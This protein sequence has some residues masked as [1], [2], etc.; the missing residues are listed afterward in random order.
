MKL[1]EVIEAL[2]IATRADGRS[3]R[4]VQAYREKLGHLVRFLGDPP[5]EAV[6]VDDLRRWVADMHDRGLS[7]FTISTR[8]K[9]VRRLFTWLE[10]EGLLDDNPAHKVKLPHPKRRTPKGLSRDDVLAL[11]AACEGSEP[12]DLRDKAAI[13]LLYDSGCRAAELCGLELDALDLERGLALIVGK[14][15]KSRYAMFGPATAAAIAAWLEAR[16]DRGNCVFVGLNQ[17]SKGGLTPNGLWQ[18]INRRAKQAGIEGPVSVHGFRHS[19]SRAYLMSGGDLGAL[20]QTLG[21]SD[22]RTTV[23]YYGVF[24]V[25]QLQELHRRHSPMAGLFGGDEDANGD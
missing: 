13:C 24:A 15:D 18:I 16:P 4:T 9:A 11:L 19:F 14:G 12:A 17:R 2:A 1:S 21:H 20:S 23:D 10:S 22:V 3:P 6:T 25:G 7:L 8:G 5:I